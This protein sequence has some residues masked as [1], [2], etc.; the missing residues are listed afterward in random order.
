M[1]ILRIASSLSGHRIVCRVAFV[2]I[3]RVVFVIILQCG[4]LIV[5]HIC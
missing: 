1:T 2:I 4:D 5:F 3:F